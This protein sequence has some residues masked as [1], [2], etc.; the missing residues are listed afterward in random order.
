VRNPL[1]GAAAVAAVLGLM[2]PTLT[3]AADDDPG[4]SQWPTIAKPDNAGGGVSDPEPGTRPTVVM[5][6]VGQ[7]EDP[8]PPV[9]PVPVQN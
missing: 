9:W 8:S 2:V 5:P 4:P 3:A 7:G 6:D 1:R